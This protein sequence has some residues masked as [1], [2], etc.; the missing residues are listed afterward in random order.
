MRYIRI[1]H[2]LFVSALAIFDLVLTALFGS[3]LPGS[4]YA[5]S[6]LAF[7]GIILLI[8]NDNLTETIVKA[9]FLALWMDMN[10]LGS[11]PVFLVSYVISVTLMRL[12]QRQI[13]SSFLEFSILA[14]VAIFIKENIKFIMIS[15]SMNVSLGYSIYLSNYILP[16]ILLNLI[17]VYPMILFYKKI[18]HL[19]LSRTQNLRSY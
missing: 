3:F 2:F 6:N 13:N 12:W 14:M 15:Q 8:Q 9:L 11:F 19:I 4:V 17:F 7:L 18:H 16:T 10:H 5:I 1:M